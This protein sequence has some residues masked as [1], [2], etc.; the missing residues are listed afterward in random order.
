MILDLV[1]SGSEIISPPKGQGEFLTIE[2]PVVE[3]MD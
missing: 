2:R 3:G 1:Y